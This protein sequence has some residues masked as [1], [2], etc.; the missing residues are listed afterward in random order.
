MRTYSTYTE[1]ESV[2]WEAGCT[3][4]KHDAGYYAAATPDEMAEHCEESGEED[5]WTELGA[6]HVPF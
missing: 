2:A 3:V 4:W 5:R 6:E 1:A